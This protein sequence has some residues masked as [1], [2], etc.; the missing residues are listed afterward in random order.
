MLLLDHV[1]NGRERI[2]ADAHRRRSGVVWF[3]VDD[4]FGLREPE[5]SIDDGS[6]M[7]FSSD[8]DLR[9]ACNS[10]YE[11]AGWVWRSVAIA[12]MSAGFSLTRKQKRT[13]TFHT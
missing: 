2:V 5:H 12:P 1:Q 9:S 4:R 11:S 6:V 3:A 10:A 13:I 8:C 7:L